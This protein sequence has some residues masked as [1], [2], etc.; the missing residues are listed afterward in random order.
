MIY[1]F[2]I[3][4]MYIYIYSAGRSWWVGWLGG[5]T[6]VYI[7]NNNMCIYREKKREKEREREKKKEREREKSIF[8]FI[9][10]HVPSW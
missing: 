5:L 3:H 4:I 9:F 1:T 6:Y 2:L 7:K 10:D 8:V